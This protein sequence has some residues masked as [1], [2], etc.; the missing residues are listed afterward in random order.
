MITLEIVSHL[1]QAVL[2]HPGSR[3]CNLMLFASGGND[4]LP[5][6]VP[7]N[8]ATGDADYAADYAVRSA[9]LRVQA[10]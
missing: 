10:T 2:L 6:A 1:K 4:V 8:H 3:I 7:L 5:T 9:R